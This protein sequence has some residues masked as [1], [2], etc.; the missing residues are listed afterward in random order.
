[1]DAAFEAREVNM[2]RPQAVRVLAVTFFAPLVLTLLLCVS[3]P[4]SAAQQ[5]RGRNWSAVQ[6]A[7]GRPG[8]LQPGN[9]IKFGMPRRDLHVIVGITT[10]K[11]ALALGSWVAFKPARRGAVV[12]GDLVLTEDEVG[13]VMAKLQENG[14]E[15][16]A[17]HHH[18]IG[19]SPRLIYMHIASQGDEVKMAQGLHDTLGLTKTPGPDR[20]AATQ[21]QPLPGIDQKK[22]EDLLGLNGQVNGGVLQ[23]SEPRAEVITDH[24]TMIPAAMGVATAINFQPTDSG[25]AA[26]AG[27]FVLLAKE[28]NPVMKALSG[29]GI[30]VTALHSHMLNEQPRLFFMHFWANDDAL[31]LAK[32]LRTA[33]DL[34]NSKK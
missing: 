9:V 33:L 20:A 7:I 5:K 11:P 22:I 4:S 3:G 19:E 10:L 27:D 21:S 13:P 30:A 15:I 18:L 17:V 25:R 8:Q 29:N 32:G 34:T 26:I 6:E 1:L 28:V 2:T 12:M 23:F 14:I 16:S 31:K 24:A